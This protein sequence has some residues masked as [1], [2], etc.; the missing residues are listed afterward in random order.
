MTLDA[1][2]LHVGSFLRRQVGLLAGK[3]AKRRLNELRNTSRLPRAQHDFLSEH[4]EHHPDNDVEFDNLHRPMRLSW[5]EI[6]VEDMLGM[7]G[8]GSVCLVTCP[9]LRKQREREERAAASRNNKSGA[10]VFHHGD[11]AS[12][13]YGMSMTADD[14]SFGGSMMLSYASTTTATGYQKPHDPNKY[15]ACKSLSNKT[16]KQ[17]NVRGFVQ[18]AADLVHEA[19]LLSHINPHPNLVRLYGIPNGDIESAFDCGADDTEGGS[20]SGSDLGYFLILEALGGGILSDKVHD[21]KQRQS[22]LFREQQILR[23]RQEQQQQRLPSPTLG[24][25]LGSP[26]E[27]RKSHTGRAAEKSLSRNP[28]YQLPTLEERLD[29][30]L[31]IA[32]GMQHLHSHGVVFRDLKPHNVGL[33]VSFGSPSS[34]ATA[35]AEQA[36]ASPQPPTPPQ[37]T[38]RLFDFGLAREVPVSASKTNTNSPRNGSKGSHH[39]VASDPSVC[40][41]KAGSL[42][43]M[44]PE[45]MGGRWLRSQK[46]HNACCFATF[47]SDVYSFA[48]V[49]WELIGIQ[50]FDKRYDASPEDFESA[51]CDRGHRPGMEALDRA[52]EMDEGPL[53]SASEEAARRFRHGNLRELVHACWREDYRQRPTFDF[54][55]ATLKEMLPNEKDDDD[56]AD[57][58]DDNT[59]A[60]DNLNETETL[61]QTGALQHHRQQGAMAPPLSRDPKPEQHHLRLAGHSVRS[62]SQHSRSRRRFM[63]KRSN[64]SLSSRSVLSNHSMSTHSMVLEDVFETENE[65]SKS[66]SSSRN[67]E[68]ENENVDDQSMTHESMASLMNESVITIENKEPSSR[69][70]DYCAD[71]NDGNGNEIDDNQT[72]SSS[73][74]LEN[75]IARNTTATA[76]NLDDGVGPSRETRSNWDSRTRMRPSSISSLSNLPTSPKIFPGNKNNGSRNSV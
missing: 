69:Y 64:R 34:P 37:L 52:I 46:H 75:S 14:S 20:E 10:L 57:N 39:G 63:K 74:L 25:F 50:N 12:C 16:I 49:L 70:L 48:I 60:T 31:Q 28:L 68:N 15:Y 59:V 47:G 61:S 51:V 4:N 42:R 23:K 67:N 35:S 41:G 22:N 53:E 2:S 44:A 73:M 62:N 33:S 11:D 66:N 9:K 3:T 13:S 18:A 29:I 7:G 24:S 72:E 38:W 17:A 8:F 21:W 56:D 36:Q 30:A 32:S 58:N 27:Q 54:I 71:Y 45:T 40:Y 6:F 43:Y 5:D 65:L 19:F 76:A 1:S 26:I 55:V